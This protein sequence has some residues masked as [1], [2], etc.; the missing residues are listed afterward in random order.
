MKRLAT[1]GQ[2]NEKAHQIY[3]E[4]TPQNWYFK[5]SLWTKCTQVRNN[6]KMNRNPAIEIEEDKML[7]KLAEYKTVDIHNSGKLMFFPFEYV[8]LMFYVTFIRKE[9]KAINTNFI[10]V[11]RNG[12]KIAL[13]DISYPSTICGEKQEMLYSKSFQWSYQIILSTKVSINFCDRSRY[14]QLF[15]D[16][17]LHGNKTA[18]IHYATWSLQM[19]GAKRI[20]VVRG[21]FMQQSTVPDAS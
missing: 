21:A 15:A 19:A 1:I 9:L 12:N 16:S 10:F 14:H 6:C 2:Y 3:W 7:I 17:M 13:G 20:E 8:W 5:S 4:K 11:S 18:D